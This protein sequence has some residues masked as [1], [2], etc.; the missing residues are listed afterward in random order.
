MLLTIIGL[1]KENRALDKQR[2]SRDK[3]VG[4]GQKVPFSKWKRAF[5]EGK[6]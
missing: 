6:Q 4:A 2:G 3:F 5:V 1:D